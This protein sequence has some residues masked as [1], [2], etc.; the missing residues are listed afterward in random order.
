MTVFGHEG[1]I[2]NVCQFNFYDWCYFRESTSKFPFPSSILGRV[3]GPADETAGNQM[4]QWILRVDGLI[5]P[6]HTAR[7]LTSAELINQNKIAK[8]RAF[9][10]AITRKLGTSMSPPPDTNDYV[11]GIFDPYQDED[12]SPQILEDD[13][14]N[15]YDSIINAE[16]LLPHQG[17]QTHA[18]VVGPALDKEGKVKGRLDDN[19]LLNTRI[20]G[21]MFPDGAVKQYAATVIAENMWAQVDHE[22]HQYLLLDHITDHRSDDTAIKKDDQYIV[23]KRGKRHLRQTTK[24]WSLCVL[25]KDGSQ[26]WISLK[27]LKESNP[28]EIAEYA[29][30]KVQMMGPIHTKETC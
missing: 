22:G 28:V 4:C 9:D 18:T 10:L 30:A 8:R 14:D 20:Y 5:V 21:V 17:K 19:P 3:L 25:W 13:D 7:P 11:D 26:Q 2:S 12:E 23:T 6:R 16:V 1:Y 15:R 27:D 24:G 29:K